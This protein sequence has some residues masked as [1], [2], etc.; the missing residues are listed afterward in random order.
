MMSRFLATIVILAGL[1][2][3]T[4]VAEIHV[5]KDFSAVAGVRFRLSAS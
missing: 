4:T 5:L 2:G 3:L 1:A